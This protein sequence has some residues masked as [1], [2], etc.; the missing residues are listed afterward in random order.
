MTSL[1]ELPSA[2]TVKTG[3]LAAIK[4][5]CTPAAHF[6]ADH[7]PLGILVVVVLAALISVLDYSLGPVVAGY[8][9]IAVR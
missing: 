6:A 9:H 3:R 7:M 2:S 1:F 4:T 8:A 5:R